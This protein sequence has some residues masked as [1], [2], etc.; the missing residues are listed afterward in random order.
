MKVSIIIVNYNVKFYLEQCIRS[1]EKAGEGISHEIIV[2]DNNSSD[3]SIAF[4]KERFPQVTFIENKENLGFAKANNQAIKK[5]KGEYI[6]LLNPDTI[7]GESALQ[8]CVTFMDN[9]PN[10]GATGVKMLKSNGK[11]A[12]ESRRGIPTPFTSMCK[13]LG[14]CKL[15]PYS[16]TFGKYY[17]QYLDPEQI[18]QIEIISGACMFI[19]KSALDKSGTLDEDF[20]MYGEDIDLS[21]R[22]LKTGMNNYYIPTPILHYKGE[23]TEKTSYRYVYVFYQAMLIFFRKHYSHYSLFLSI[24]IKAAIYSKAICSFMGQQLRRFINKTNNK[25]VSDKFIIIA[26]ES[27]IA[28][29]T[30]ILERNKHK[31]SAMPIKQT[32][33]EIPNITEGNEYKD[34]DYA[35]YDSAHTT[36]S[37][38]LEQISA[39]SKRGFSPKLAVYHPNSNIIITEEQVWQ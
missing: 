23:S 8:D 28:K 1:I 7:L 17:M 33:K 37:Y 30:R 36:Y 27:S 34:F 19:R 2:A 20:F 6:M 4:L 25:E 12:L 9:T 32:C 22:L 15:F 38:M 11:F 13:M 31:Y 14:L 26:P 39:S 3:D 24:P 5:A 18:S 21:Y 35:V 29:I 10:A 16:K